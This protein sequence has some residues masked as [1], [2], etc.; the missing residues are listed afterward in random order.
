[1]NLKEMQKVLPAPEYHDELKVNRQKEKDLIKWILFAH[2]KF[3]SQYDTIVPYVVEKDI[4]STGKNIFDC[5]KYNFVYD[6]EGEGDQTV[7][8]LSRIVN[9][10]EPIDCKHYA[11][12]SG[13]LLDAINR[14]YYPVNWFY[15]FASY[16][17]DPVAKHVF[18][19]FMYQG[20]EIYLDPVFGRYNQ[21]DKINFYLDRKPQDMAIYMLSGP[22]AASGAVKVSS[23]LAETNFLV[24]VNQNWNGLK[25][26]L[27]SNKAILNNQ[28]KPWYIA[29]GYNFQNLLNIL[30]N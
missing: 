25:T 16:D 23:K 7:R 10:G 29:N 21:H 12:V 1:M 11:L 14:N 2:E 3:A 30:N 27:N 4:Y 24:L 18:V 8:S 26:L 13:G 22:P 17:N 9:D 5:L 6:A 28:V 20:K 15:R 19:V